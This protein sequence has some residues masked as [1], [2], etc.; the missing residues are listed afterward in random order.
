MVGSA[1]ALSGGCG[2]GV[3]SEEVWRLRGE[4]QTEEAPDRKPPVQCGD[5]TAERKS[6]AQPVCCFATCL[7]PRGK[8]LRNGKDG[9]R[10]QHGRHRHRGTRDAGQA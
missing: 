4:G 2:V 8:M 1:V 7:L 10:G 3:C 5:I 9:W 6:G